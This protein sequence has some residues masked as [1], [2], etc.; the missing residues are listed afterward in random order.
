ML[1]PNAL[2]DFVGLVLPVGFNEQIE[3]ISDSSSDGWWRQW[4]PARSTYKSLWKE[5]AVCPWDSGDYASSKAK[6]T[7]Y[8]CW[9]STLEVVQVVPWRSGAQG[10]MVSGFILI[11]MFTMK[12]VLQAR[13]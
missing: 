1:A 8:Y 10:L 12:I 4:E 11:Q 9:F 7:Q 13:Q 3:L 2:R 6:A 5:D